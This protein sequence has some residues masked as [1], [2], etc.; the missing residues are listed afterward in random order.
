MAGHRAGGLQ[1]DEGALLKLIGRVITGSGEGAHFTQLPWARKAFLTLLGFDPFPG[2][3]NL[4]IDDADSLL[5]WQG[6]RA[7]TGTVVLPPPDSEF[8]RARCYPARLEGR[9]PAAIVCPEVPDYPQDQVELIAAV[10]IRVTLSLQEGDRLELE[11]IEK[12]G[13]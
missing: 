9:L 11:V 1:R 3:L 8:C 13:A 10:S 12:S 6:L 5:Q 7:R 4:K 2:T